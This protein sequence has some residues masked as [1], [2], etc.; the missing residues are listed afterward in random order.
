M[1]HFTKRLGESYTEGMRTV[2]CMQ[3]DGSI[4]YEKKITHLITQFHLPY[5]CPGFRN[6]PTLR[7]TRRIGAR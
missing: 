7:V 4:G 6:P 3:S 1:R 5:M 2:F